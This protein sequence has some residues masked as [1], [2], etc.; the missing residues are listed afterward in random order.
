MIDLPVLAM[1]ALDHALTRLAA[2]A[3][4]R[5]APVALARGLGRADAV[6]ALG[7]RLRRAGAD[8]KDGLGD[9]ACFVLGAVD[10]DLTCHLGATLQRAGRA[11]G[12]PSVDLSQSR[13]M[14]LAHDHIGIGQSSV[15]ALLDITN[16]QLAGRA[17]VV[18]GYG[19]M[20]AGVAFHAAALGARVT[21]V[22]DDPLRAA[23]ALA[24][25][26]SARGFAQALPR[27][28][29]LFGTN[30]GPQPGAQQVSHLSGGTILCATGPGSE[31]SSEITCRAENIR[32]VRPD[33]EAFDLPHAQGLKLIAGG[34]PL[35]F[36]GGHGIPAAAQDIVLALHVLALGQLLRAAPN[37]L[38]AA[39]LDPVEEARLAAV[40]VAAS[41]GETEG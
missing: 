39:A 7:A 29:V 4:L 36:A 6:Q 16:L 9:G 13:L 25:G 27:A 12:V 32:P 40:V 3:P 17:V 11:P 33:V 41:G 35:S 15:M 24:H 14:R 2:H 10:E 8:V 22:E 18:C 34:R 31:I 19:P 20:G 30:G 1:P 21:V 37:D 5:G 26:H 38:V 28:E 23:E